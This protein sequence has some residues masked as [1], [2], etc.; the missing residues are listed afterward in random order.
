MMAKKKLRTLRKYLFEVIVIFLGITLSFMFD[1]W[2]S[3]P[4]SEQE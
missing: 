2:R 4:N 1:E 3:A